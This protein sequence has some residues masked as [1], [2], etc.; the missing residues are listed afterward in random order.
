MHEHPEKTL[1]R[2]LAIGS[3]IGGLLGLTVSLMMDVLYADALQGT[4][5]ESIARDLNNLF[6]ISPTPHSFIVYSVYILILVVL[7][8]FGAFIGM[9]FA[10][11]VYRFFKFLESSE[12]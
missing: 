5:R 8:A 12:D 2:T 1:K 4:W 6:S 11:I 9:F 10:F 7:M 3:I